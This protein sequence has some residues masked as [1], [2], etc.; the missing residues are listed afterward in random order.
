MG[1]LRNLRGLL[2]VAAVKDLEIH[3]MD[4]V[5]AF[6]N[7][8]IK[9]DI[10]MQIPPLI[11]NYNTRKV[12]RLRKPLYGLKEASSYWYLNIKK[13]FEMINLTTSK[14]DPCFFTIVTPEWECYVHIHADDLTIVSNNVSRF[15]S[16]INQRFE[17][18][19][20][21]LVYYILGIA[22]S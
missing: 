11:P 9:E 21:G 6:L 7:P 12:W 20:L 15:K 16:I 8:T 1:K 3:H 19:Y 18:E 2:K 4:A 14:A 17:M 13:F 22:V 5:A 10:Y